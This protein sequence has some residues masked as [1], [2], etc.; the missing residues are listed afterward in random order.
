M[1]RRG[2]HVGLNDAT[3]SYVIAHSDMPPNWWFSV[4]ARMVR[5]AYRSGHSGLHPRAIEYLL[6]VVFLPWLRRVIS[7]HHIDSLSVERLP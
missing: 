3:D 5:G 4:D 1:S 7:R 6:E 2:W